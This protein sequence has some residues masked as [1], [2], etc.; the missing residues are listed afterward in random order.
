MSGHVS[1]AIIDGGP[2]IFEKMKD[3][4]SLYLGR[5]RSSTTHH[6][7]VADAKFLH[8]LKKLNRLKF[9]SLR[10]ISLITELPSFISNLNDLKILDLKAPHNLE[11][12][13]DQ[14]SLF[15][16]LTHLDMSEC[17]FVEYMPKGLAQLSNLE[18]LGIPY[19]RFYEQQVIMYSQ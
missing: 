15:K 10:G 5:W 4:Q 9:L 17:Y 7:E 14:I 16:S 19:W 8:G 1:E 6:I 12:I 3:I 13:P 2:G 18:V 11:V